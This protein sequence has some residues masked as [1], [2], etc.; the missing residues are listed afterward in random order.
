[1][2]VESTYHTDF[3]KQIALEQ[4]IKN[5]ANLVPQN[6]RD[7]THN[8]VSLDEA[9]DVALRLST[10]LCETIIAEHPDHGDLAELSIGQR[11]GRLLGQGT[12]VKLRSQMDGHV[13]TIVHIWNKAL[14]EMQRS[15][16]Q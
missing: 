14:Q 5:L 16:T 13:N 12:S 3:P 4:Q 9:K 6:Y 10:R 2:T 7:L 1:M 8:G 11:F 15:E